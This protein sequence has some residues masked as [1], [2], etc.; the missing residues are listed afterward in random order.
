MI[1]RL[2][3]R[4]SQLLGQVLSYVERPIEFFP[5]FDTLRSVAV[6]SSSLAATS[7]EVMHGQMDA[8]LPEMPFCFRAFQYRDQRGGGLFSSR[9][10]RSG[11]WRCPVPLLKLRPRQFVSTL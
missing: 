4:G 6:L 8:I 3:K 7:G 2:F 5:L 9:K 1:S 11:D 10:A